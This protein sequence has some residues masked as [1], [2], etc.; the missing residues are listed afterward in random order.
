MFF[1]LPAPPPSGRSEFSSIPV[2]F[3]LKRC[4]NLIYLYKIR[5]FGILFQEMEANFK[6]GPMPT[7]KDVAKAAGVSY[8]TV[9]N[10]LNGK[11]FVKSKTIRQVE[12]AARR[13]GYIA[14]QQARYLR[15]GRSNHLA[16]I[17]PNLYGHQYIDFYLSFKKYAEGF[18]Y[19]TDL[20]LTDNNGDREKKELQIISENTVAGIAVFTSMR[21]AEELYRA[22]LDH[23]IFV[24]RQP[25]FPCRTVFFDMV[26]AGEDAA[27]WA[28]A[29]RYSQVI[30]IGESLSFSSMGD[31][32]KGFNRAAPQNRPRYQFIETDFQHCHN[33][34][35]QWLEADKACD[36]LICT[37]ILFAGI[38]NNAKKVYFSNLSFAVYSIAPQA[39]VPVQ[40]GI[41]R[42]EQDY[43][44]LGRSAAKMLIEKEPETG[45][46]AR[47]L[48]LEN[49]GLR[50]WIPSRVV[51]LEK[52]TLI[53]S[54]GSPTAGILRNIS[55]IYRQNTGVEIKIALYS[56][57]FPDGLNE[58][59]SGAENAGAFDIIRTDVYRLP[60]YAET[61]LYPLSEIDSGIDSLF[62]DFLPGLYKAYSLHKGT[63]YALP[64]TPSA[65]LLFYRR[66]LFESTVLCR[67]FFE[68]YGR[69]LKIPGTYEDFNR[70]SRFFTRF[71]NPHS[72]VDYGTNLILGNTSL[73]AKEFLSRFFSYTES[74]YNAG[75]EIEIAGQ[76]GIKAMEDLLELRD[77]VNPRFYSSAPEAARAFA[78]GET[79]MAKIFSNSAGELIAGD[80]R[81][82]DRLGYAMTPG[83]NPLIGGG[84]IGVCRYSKHKNEALEFIEWLSR[85]TVSGAMTSMGSVSPCKAVYENYGIIDNY[86]WLS[87]AKDCFS[88][89]RTNYIPP[90]HCGIFDETKF[91]NSIAMA[92]HAV[93]NGIS[94]VSEALGKIRIKEPAN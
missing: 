58:L 14:N 77:C 87:I 61:V 48:C 9:S 35:F 21:K 88:L 59:L 73:A 5:R 25:G 57:D 11:G 38:L 15:R 27:K 60:Q 68:E 52:L 43:R 78:S 81:V 49:A 50:R 71:F 20:Y 31:F 72:P 85:E 19:H 86:P 29:N 10:V 62:D 24:E 53:T 8:S 75:G 82:A 70:I 66:D 89:S 6:G 1:G 79:A 40:D 65:E 18:N 42:Y 13:L 23:T 93:F 17:L 30:I 16:L 92:V 12:E 2:D 80:S 64:S 94:G 51:K 55:K 44:L 56:P 74:L 91:L 37:N 76:A 47:S 67:Q 39:A 41:I 3:S 28:A 33:D 83:N 32:L 84:I 34:M 26:K 45:E 54:I 63:I 90:N 7:I 22:Y 46:T 4:K 36:A 69:E